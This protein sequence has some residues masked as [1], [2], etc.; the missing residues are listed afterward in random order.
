MR[1][2]YQKIFA[3]L[4]F[5]QTF[6]IS[7]VI[8]Q[9]TYQSI[10]LEFEKICMLDSVGP[11]KQVQFW[12]VW[13]INTSSWVAVDTSLDI[14]NPYVPIGTQKTCEAGQVADI[15]PMCDIDF[16]DVD[17]AFTYDAS[18]SF[19]VR[20]RNRLSF[21][22]S[23]P[24]SGL[25]P[26]ANFVWDCGQG[27]FIESDNLVSAICDY[28]N[29]P[30]GIYYIKLGINLT[31][32]QGIHIEPIFSVTIEDGEL[33]TISGNIASS[34]NIT[35]GS[36]SE[37]SMPFNSTQFLRKIYS[38]GTSVDV[39]Y[40]NQP[41]TVQDSAS[42]CIDNY[43]FDFTDE[44]VPSTRP[45]NLD[46]VGPECWEL[47]KSAG[48]YNDYSILIPINI[49]AIDE[50]AIDGSVIPLNTVYNLSMSD[51]E[52][53]LITDLSA[54]FD[55]QGISYNSISIVYDDS[56][57]VEISITGL[58]SSVSSIAA[59]YNAITPSP[60]FNLDN[61]YNITT[62]ST[63]FY[64]VYRYEHSGKE[65]MTIDQNGNETV[66]PGSSLKVKCGG[67]S[68]TEI[69]CDVENI[70]GQEEIISS[71]M[72]LVAG[73]YNSVILT[74]LSGTAIITADNDTTTNLVGISRGWDAKECEFITNDIIIDASNGHVIL[75]TIR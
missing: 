11:N 40:Q 63:L 60:L 57:D 3:C 17:V 19:N 56:G 36:Y 30:D 12:K 28:N 42:V 48:T 18:D 54:Y 69:N 29:I 9:G 20:H 35:V 25:F 75:T 34:V 4:F 61:S 59:S 24:L 14:T 31:G 66:L 15:V 52:S 68:S 43:Q 10:D 5:A 55:S 72:T 37:Q 44:F 51:E 1:K 38:D 21:Q 26:I 53:R 41:Y 73:T 2:N 64:D 62:D 71:S 39:D 32:V 74:V 45:S 23:S 27:E 22:R 65:A 33:L 58:D 46:I 70:A 8:S 16:R 67:A 7:S 6:L 49:A 13:N 50:I 47:T